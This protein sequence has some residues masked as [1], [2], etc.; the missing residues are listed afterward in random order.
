MTRNQCVKC[1]TIAEHYGL[2][3]QEFQ[4]ISGLSELLEVLTRRMS[5]RGIDWNNDLLDEL[6]DVTIMVQQMCAL[7]RISDN[8][9][10]E[11]VNYKLNRQIERIRNGE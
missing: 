7:H 6:A 1:Q 5:Q 9:L 11:R 10:N 8:E 2:Q 4:T 3:T